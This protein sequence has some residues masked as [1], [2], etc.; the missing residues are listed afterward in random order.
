[1]LGRH[2]K[3]PA[4]HATR[5]TAAVLSRADIINLLRS[6]GSAQ[7][8][9]FAEARHTRERIWGPRVILRGV[10]EVTN[11]CRVDCDYCP[12]RRSN[13]KQTD[14]FDGDEDA[15]LSAVDEIQSHGIDIVFLQGGETPH[16]SDVV[17]GVIPKVRERYDDKVELLL[18]LGDLPDDHY[19]RFAEAGATS[20]ILK[21]ETSDPELHRKMRGRDLEV[22]LDRLRSLLRLGYR[23]GTGTI[24]G[25]PGQPFESLAD[26]ILLAHELGA[27]MMSASPFIPAESTPLAGAPLGDLDTTLNAI[28]IMR[29]MN[30]EWLIPSVSAMNTLAP[31]G[32]FQGLMAG[33]NVLTANFTTPRDQ[34]RY[35]IYG[36]S[37]HVARLASLE[38]ILTQAKLESRGSCWVS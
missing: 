2:R 10:I 3:A 35:T 33:A 26:D 20:Y 22:R 36:K 8:D 12:M 30:P 29:I 4:F 31:D 9:L 1:M 16:S 11:V 18:C 28:A 19:Q 7:A 17:A 6:A 21:H 13:L 23:V 24:V 37:R 25:L 5:G 38:Q 27:H 14:R 34:R 15:I 32:Q